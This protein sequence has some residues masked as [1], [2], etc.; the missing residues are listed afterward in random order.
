M[1]Q[2]ASKRGRGISGRSGHACRRGS[3]RY[4]FHAHSQ[5][6]K[7]PGRCTVAELC[8][9]RKQLLILEVH[10]VHRASQ[11]ASLRCFEELCALSAGDVGGEVSA[12]VPRGAREPAS[13][14]SIGSRIEGSPGNEVAPTAWHWVKL[15]PPL[16]QG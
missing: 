16:A 6:K 2:D 5:D 12:F 1:E 4:T 9:L 10:P 11:R 7:L 8:V 15:L 13:L 14:E 3:L